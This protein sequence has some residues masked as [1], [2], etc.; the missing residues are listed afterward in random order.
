M[1]IFIETKDYHVKKLHYPKVNEVCEFSSR[2]ILDDGYATKIKMC[3]KQAIV[4]LSHKKYKFVQ[5]FCCQE[6]LD[7]LDK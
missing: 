4:I 3:S 1:N 7:S 5:A 2:T 6:C